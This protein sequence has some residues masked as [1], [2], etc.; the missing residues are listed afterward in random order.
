MKFD[1]KRNTF[2]ENYLPNHEIGIIHLAGKH[3]D[4][5]RLNKD[6][7]SEVKTLDNKII[8]KNLR[9]KH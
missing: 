5:I 1:T 9:F 6:H 8:K 4:G 7:L 3:N 2:V